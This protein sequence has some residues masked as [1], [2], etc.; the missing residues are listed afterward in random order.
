MSEVSLK[1][2]G[3]LAR[4]LGVSETTIERMR[5]SNSGS[6]PP[7]LTIGNRL[8]RYDEATVENWLAA[9]SQIQT[10]LEKDKN[11]TNN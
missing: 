5:A 8:V 7:H 2:T 4:R 11:V 1:D 3:W 9:Q 6:I 10:N